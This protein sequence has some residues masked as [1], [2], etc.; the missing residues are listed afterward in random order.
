MAIRRP[1]RERSDPGRAVDDRATSPGVSAPFSSA[2]ARWTHGL[3]VLVAT[4]MVV[5]SGI[6]LVWDEIY[7]DNALVS[8]GWRGSDLVT[9][10]VAVPLL[11]AA[12]RASRRGGRRSRL[13]TLGM[14][15][16][17]FYGYA[18]YLFGAA[19]NGL[20]L[21]YVAIVTL[22]GTGLLL[23][24][25]DL[26]P[27]PFRDRALTMGGAPMVAVFL[28]GVGT[29]LA[30]FW[31]ALSV[32]YLVT[33]RPP[34]M[35][36][37]TGHPTNVTGALDLSLVVPLALVAGLWLW[38]RRPWGYALAVVWTV[39]GAV[40][41]L[42]LSAATLS[43]YRAGAAED[44]AQLLLWVPIA[45]GCAWASVA[46]LRNAPGGAP[47][48]GSPPR[49][50]RAL[51]LFDAKIVREAVVDAS[52][53]VTYAAISRTNLLDP[54][55]RSL[56]QVRELPSRFLSWVGGAE[57]AARPRS[58]TLM[59]FLGP[60]TGMVRVAEEPGV[61]IVV[62]SVG[63]FWEKDYGHAR[64]SGEDFSSF[65]K[66]GFAKLAMGFWVRPTR[67]GKS[68]LRYE[69]RTATTDDEAKRRF[70]RYWRV[71]RPGVWLVMGRAVRL[72]RREAERRARG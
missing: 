36:V 62:G 53:D 19:F 60:D 49:L 32:N 40:Y 67:D 14:L 65:R 44:R 64:V 29:L 63:R 50:E 20:F 33:G 47:P 1:R 70:R 58:V 37:A 8:A 68:L 45:A 30:V 52:P 13:V 38:R 15:L 25:M 21:V 3:A 72:V 43:A 46:L 26:D 48:E 6:G 28:I 5:A 10:V 59:D 34:A 69:A 42:A 27:T 57:P 2:T 12:A 11:L 61:E 18:F 16:Y 71:I 17:A 35:V 4:L 7:R 9:L 54:V 23:G 55:I 41:M 24:L 22:S 31:I 56:F 66:P 51:P 39:K